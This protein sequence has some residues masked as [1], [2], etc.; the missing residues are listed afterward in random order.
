[1]HLLRVT[2]TNLRAFWKCNPIELAPGVTLL[3]GKNNSGK[4]TLLEALA[5]EGIE[6]VC[7]L[8]QQHHPCQ[9]YL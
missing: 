9:R 5:G 6:I 8:E 2:P 1:M 3:F 7:R 4:T